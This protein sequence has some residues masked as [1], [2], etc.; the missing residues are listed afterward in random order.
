MKSTEQNLRPPLPQLHEI[1]R[2]EDPNEPIYCVPTERGNYKTYLI[3]AVTC[4]LA[5]CKPYGGGNQ[6]LVCFIG[7]KPRPG[8]GLMVNVVGGSHLKTN[9]RRIKK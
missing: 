3:P 5:P 9:P 6:R 8:E 2:P 7:R 1:I 4:W